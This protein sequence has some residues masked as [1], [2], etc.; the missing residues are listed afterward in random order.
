MKIGERLREAW[1]FLWHGESALSY[2]AFTIVS[3]ITLSI[4]YQVFLFFLGFFGVED[5]FVVITSSMIHS[6]DINSSYYEWMRVHGYNQSQMSSWSFPEGLNLGDLVVVM[7]VRPQEL[8]VG[9]VIVYE[10]SESGYRI[11]HRIIFINETGG[12]ILFTTKGDANYGVMGFEKN[13]TPRQVVGRAEARVP[14]V[15]IPKMVLTRALMLL[16]RA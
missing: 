8:E 2:L 6:N 4:L 7:K 16:Q 5:L 11:I 15:G 14:F 10:P 9:D 13:L 12:K 3:F 1:N